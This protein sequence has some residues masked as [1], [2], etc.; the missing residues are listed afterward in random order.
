[1]FHTTTTTSVDHTT[2]LPSH[3]KGHPLLNQ[4]V[5]QAAFDTHSFLGDSGLKVS[6]ICLGTMTFGHMDKDFG[7]RPGQLSESECHQILDRFVELGGNFIDT[8][9]FYPWFGTCAGESEKYIGRW[10]AR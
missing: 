10:L 5:K 4:M 7:D 3:I 2:F 1:M 8:A 6:K 9:N